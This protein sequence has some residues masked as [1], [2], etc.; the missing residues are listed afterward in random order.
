MNTMLPVLKVAGISQ[1]YGHSTAL[2]DVSFEISDGE[3]LS[4]VGPSGCG[5]TTLLKIMAGIISPTRGEVRFRG[6]PISS[7]SPAEHG[8]LMMWQSLAL[9]SH[10]NVADNVGFGLAI[11]NIEAAMRKRLVA[12]ALALVELAGFENRSIDT[13]SGGEQQ[14]VALARALVLKPA[15]LL[16]DEPVQ[17][18][19]RHLRSRLIG[20]I[21][22]LHHRLQITMVMVTHEQSEALSL[23]TRIAVMR[24]GRIEQI[25]TPDTVL[26]RP[27]TRFVA[28][29]LGDRNVLVGRILEVR[30]ERVLIDTSAGKFTASLPNWIS[31][32]P[33]PGQEVAY[34]I[35]AHNVSV[36]ERGENKIAATVESVI[37]TG[38]SESIELANQ[39]VSVIKCHRSRT[40]ATDRLSIGKI[41]T[42]SW[43][44]TSA[45]V[46]PSISD[47]L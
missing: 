29:F 46:L 9:F 37:E 3:F 20:T 14:R 44:A 38:V 36:D 4:V 39:G 35:D 10:L 32:R 22:Q 18:L 8:I 26:H 34:V 40:A 23:S 33:Q 24:H 43:S 1:S 16:L 21:R 30:K 11:R 25:D 47:E 31:Y 15:V 41:V 6:A 5:K 7:F 45:Y 42:L 27:N 13:L 19:D 17:G 28:E 12:E 2:R